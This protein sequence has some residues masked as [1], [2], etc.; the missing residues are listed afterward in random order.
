[1]TLKKQRKRFKDFEFTDPKI[2]YKKEYFDFLAAFQ[3]SAKEETL[4]RI[5]LSKKQIERGNGLLEMLDEIEQTRDKEADI[6]TETLKYLCS[7]TGVS[8]ED[9]SLIVEPTLKDVLELAAENITQSQLQHK[10]DIKELRKLLIKFEEYTGYFNNLRKYCQN[11]ERTDLDLVT[12][13][14]NHYREEYLEKFDIGLMRSQDYFEHRVEEYKY[15]RS[16]IKK[17]KAALKTL[18]PLQLKIA[19]VKLAEKEQTLSDLHDEVT[20]YKKDLNFR[21]DIRNYLGLVI[22]SLP[23]E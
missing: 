2:T 22:E 17:E 14:P 11:P 13:I 12:D 16:L 5:K 18:P 10:A 21:S 4:K 23:S 7:M 6:K 20:W 1:M 19:K 9:L 3:V 8:Y 15:L